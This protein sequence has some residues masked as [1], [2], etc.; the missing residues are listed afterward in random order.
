M[1]MLA[2]ASPTRLKFRRCV[3]LF[4]V[5]NSVG[6]VSGFMFRVGSA[7]SGNHR[8]TSRTSLTTFKFSGSCLGYIS[9]DVANT[10]A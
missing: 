5:L 2:N 8:Y 6:G 4:V 7:L 3:L 10:K 9:I 1:R